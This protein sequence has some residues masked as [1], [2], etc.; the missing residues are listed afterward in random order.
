MQIC[1]AK[2]RDC[3]EKNSP[4]TFNCSTTCSGIYADVQWVGSDIEEEIRDETIEVGELNKRAVDDMMQSF[5][6]LKR[7]LER[8]IKLIKKD[9]G[10]GVDEQD[11]KIYKRL[12]ADYRKFKTRNVKYYYFNNAAHLSS[13]GRGYVVCCS[14][15]LFIR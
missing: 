11:K 1:D 15:F 2:G 6:T 4:E 12:I 3:I 7:E 9:I 13:Y 8:E 10:K 5:H 14:H